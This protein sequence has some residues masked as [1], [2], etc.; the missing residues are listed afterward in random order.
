MFSMIDDSFLGISVHN[1]Y[2]GAQDE[3]DHDNS[4]EMVEFD[5]VCGDAAFEAW[6]STISTICFISI[7]TNYKTNLLKWSTLINV[8]QFVSLGWITLFHYK[9]NIFKVDIIFF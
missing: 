6:V 1:P 2:E 7:T 4:H 5:F 9:W 8:I 3:D